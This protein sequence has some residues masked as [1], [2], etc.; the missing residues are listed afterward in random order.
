MVA[1]RLEIFRGWMGEKADKKAGG[2]GAEGK[3]QPALL[4]WPGWVDYGCFSESCN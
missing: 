1:G 4:Y 3:K 2:R